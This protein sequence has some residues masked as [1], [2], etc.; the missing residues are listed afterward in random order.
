MYKR[1]YSFCELVTSYAEAGERSLVRSRTDGFI[2]TID[3]L[4]TA[5]K[6]FRYAAILKA[7]GL[8]DPALVRVDNQPKLI[9]AK[10]R[11]VLADGAISSILGDVYELDM[12]L[13]KLP[14]STETAQMTGEILA[15][16]L[17]CDLYSGKAS[18]EFDVTT[19]RPDYRPH[20]RTSTFE[21]PA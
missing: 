19:D 2:V 14:V 4:P 18:I 21:G 3:A 12:A 1:Q 9:S 11:V 15:R 17:M 16:D 6:G 8:L 13:R 7:Y 5:T 20:V 10:A